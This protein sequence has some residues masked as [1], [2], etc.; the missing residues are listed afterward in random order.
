MH[1]ISIDYVYDN[2]TNKF[3]LFSILPF[4][5]LGYS[6]QQPFCRKID[7]VTVVYLRLP[8]LKSNAASIKRHHSK[9]HVEE[10]PA[11]ERSSCCILVS[12][13]CCAQFHQVTLQTVVIFQ[14]VGEYIIKLFKHHKSLFNLHDSHL[15]FL[16]IC[17]IMYV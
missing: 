3:I 12:D 9:H 2:R 4:I 16:L 15:P 14:T 17:Y 13:C 6:F 10:F 11:T 8:A 1:K 5:K 7:S